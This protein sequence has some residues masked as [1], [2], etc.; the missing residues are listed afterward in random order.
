[1]DQIKV[2]KMEA[3]KQI[4]RLQHSKQQH[5]AQYKSRKQEYS[6][7]KT[8]LEH[9]MSEYNVL[10][11]AD[12]GTPEAETALEEILT[13]IEQKRSELVAGR[14]EVSRLKH[15]IAGADDELTQAR[16]ELVAHTGMMEQDAKMRAA[17]QAEERAKLEDVKEEFLNQALKDER[18][19]LAQE[20]SD[21]KG[22]MMARM[23]SFKM[24]AGFEKSRA[25]KGMEGRISKEREQRESAEAE[26]DRLRE[27]V[28]SLNERIADSEVK[29]EELTDELHRAND[30]LERMEKELESAGRTLA[31]D[32]DKAEAKEA[33]VRIEAFGEAEAAVKN[34]LEFKE[35]ADA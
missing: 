9:D 17:I 11:E 19:N 8:S 25:E 1:M 7:L 6:A 22:F 14:T 26:R 34:S 23:A 2:E 20:K 32:S 28:E 33:A 15:E 31:E 13:T 3:M 4:K 27:E 5:T 12:D 16:A 21:Q 29:E 35:Q 10:A 30:E 24:K 18:K